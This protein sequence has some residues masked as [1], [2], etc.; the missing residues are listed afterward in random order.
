MNSEG[1]N[2]IVPAEQEQ[3]MMAPEQMQQAVVQMNTAMQQLANMMAAMS[4][5][6]HQLTRR[7]ELMEKLTPGQAQELGKAVRER[8]AALLNLYGIAQTKR[9][10]G[11][12]QTLI[13]RELRNAAGVEGKSLRDL[14]KFEYQVALNRVALWDDYDAMMG[15]ASEQAPEDGG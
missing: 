10:Q 14:P 9:A 7:M 13:R 1:K 12:V 15:V 2:M 4:E 3:G 11:K 5:N 8:A 6:I